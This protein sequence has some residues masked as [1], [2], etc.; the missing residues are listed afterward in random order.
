MKLKK[1][2]YFC[3]PSLTRNNHSDG[4]TK[5]K[6]MATRI[7]LARH[8]RKKSAFY[9]IVVSDQ[10][11]PRDG[12]FIE[13]LGTYNPNTNPATINLN[14]DSAVKWILKGAQP[15]DTVRAILSYK[16]VMMKKH[17][18]GGVA[19]G[20]FSEEEADKRFEK[21][22][23]EKEKQISDKQSR[24]E[25][26]AE[27]AEKERL[28]NE[29]AKREEKTKAAAEKEATEEAPAADETLAAEETPATEETPAE[30]EKDKK[31]S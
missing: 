14:F 21:W 5:L 28:S 24:L 25:K 17:L 20:A 18:L 9:H 12:R 13:K 8:G 30:K 10:R 22:M 16:G 27:K 11:S 7:R 15:S 3:T 31:D 2:F 29:K 6:K 1:D 23:N 26:E 4:L 19:K